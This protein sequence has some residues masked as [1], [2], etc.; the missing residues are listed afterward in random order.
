MRGWDPGSF[1]LVLLLHR[2]QD[3]QGSTSGSVSETFDRPC[4]TETEKHTSH[5]PSAPG[6]M[7]QR[8]LLPRIRM[9]ALN[10]PALCKDGLRGQ[11][12]IRASCSAEAASSSELH[13]ELPASSHGLNLLELVVATGFSW[14][15]SK[16][17][18]IAHVD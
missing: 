16:I 13:G 11:T 10:T 3:E 12:P 4:R 7:N 9:Q 17:N 18:G 8:T 15:T 2:P 14:R 1:A 5:R 6:L